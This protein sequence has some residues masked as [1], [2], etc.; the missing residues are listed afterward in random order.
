MPWP[1]LL[2]ALILLS[3]SDAAGCFCAPVAD[4]VFITVVATRY[5]SSKP[6]LINSSLL[7]A[8]SAVYEDTST[9]TKNAVR[10]V[11]LLWALSGCRV[12]CAVQF[13]VS[14]SRPWHVH[15]FVVIPRLLRR[16]TL[17]LPSFVVAGTAVQ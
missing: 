6:K 17:L 15:L 10:D 16:I 7:C 12:P 8:L 11:V 2:S 3:A 13:L 1:I 9:T 5:Y 4:G 14:M